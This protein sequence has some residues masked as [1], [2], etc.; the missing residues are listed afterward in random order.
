MTQHDPSSF[1]T[2][3]LRAAGM[4]QT[5]QREAILR[6]LEAADRP[7][8]VEEIWGSMEARRSGL[9]TVYRNLERFV[10]EG[11]AESILGPDQ[12]MRFVRCHSPHHHHHL[13]CEA[14]GRMVEVDG[15]G[16]EISLAAM[17]I[18]SGF[19]VTRHT[20]H[21]FGICPQCQAEKGRLTPA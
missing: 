16:L 21:L 19:K 18:K 11:W 12:V 20:L 5:P 8:T 13:S 4:R 9:P 2:P 7:L 15:C 1:Q 14:C 10:Q 17:E 3:S 6:V